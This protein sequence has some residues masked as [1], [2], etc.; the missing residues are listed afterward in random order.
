MPP[1][2]PRGVP[3]ADGPLPRQYGLRSLPTGTAALPPRGLP[4]PRIPTPLPPR[5]ATS[6]SQS[7]PQPQ[8]YA[9]GGAASGLQSLPPR[10]VSY[11]VMTAGSRRGR[12]GPPRPSATASG[13]SVPP[14]GAAS[15][16]HGHGHGHAAPSRDH[17]YPKPAKPAA[18]AGSMR[19]AR[20][21]G[22]RHAVPPAPPARSTRYAAASSPAANRSSM[23]SLAASV[24]SVFGADVSDDEELDPIGMELE[25]AAEADGSDVPDAAYRQV[26]HTYVEENAVAVPA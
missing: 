15:R 20:E 6:Q 1:W 2:Q 12:L 26:W 21:G 10:D 17:R 23:L 4:P 19:D 22:G 8:R 24:L 13:G 3:G 9:A 5:T 14:R 16:A 11:G 25:A 18:V 7:Q